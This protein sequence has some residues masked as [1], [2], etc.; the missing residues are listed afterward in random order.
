MPEPKE[1]SKAGDPIFRHS[2][3]NAP[4]QRPDMS[5]SALEEIGAHIKHHLGPYNLILHEIV[6]DIVHLDVHVVSPNPER[7]WYTLVTSGASDLPMNPPPECESLRHAEFFINLPPHW[8]I[9]SKKWNDE[10]HYWPIRWLKIVARLAHEYK[11]WVWVGHTVPNGDPP[12]RFAKGTKMCCMLVSYP[13]SVDEGFHTLRVRDDKV[14]HFWSV[15]PIYREEIK[16]KLDEGCD[17]LFE[18][19]DEH[20]IT[21]LIDPKRTN[22]AKKRLWGLF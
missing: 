21:D 19:F 8:E 14:I 15:V 7:P 16:I 17:A 1:T 2:A 4:R 9:D 11:S 5:D 20:A 12:E 22:V 13:V 3:Q 18:K 6:S 10:S